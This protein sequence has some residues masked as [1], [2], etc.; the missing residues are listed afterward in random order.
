VICL[1]SKLKELDFEDQIL[2]ML[3]ETHMNIIRVLET[4]MLVD[5]EVKSIHDINRLLWWGN[6]F[7]KG[8]LTGHIIKDQGDKVVYKVIFR[9]DDMERLINSRIKKGE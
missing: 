5:I 2:E 3:K 6:D 7:F 9:S 4:R 8:N 1:P